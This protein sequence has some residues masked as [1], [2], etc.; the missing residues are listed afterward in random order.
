MA[1]NPRQGAGDPDA[2]L[3]MVFAARLGH[4]GGDLSVTDILATLYFG[5]MRI[6]P[7][8]PRAPAGIG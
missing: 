4:P 1:L 6:D 2:R 5:V 8:A 7:E 3:E